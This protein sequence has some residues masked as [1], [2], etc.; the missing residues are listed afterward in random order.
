MENGNNHRSADKSGG[1]VNRLTEIGCL[2]EM[3][4]TQ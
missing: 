1:V 4:Y 3:H 2:A